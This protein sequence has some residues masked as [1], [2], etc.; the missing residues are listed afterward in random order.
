MPSLKYQRGITLIE[1][2]V[3]IALFVFLIGS[4]VISA[5]YI[6]DS[7]E[8]NKSDLSVTT[9][10]QFLLRKIDWAL[11]GVTSITSPSSGNSDGT[12]S[13]NKAG[14][15]DI[16]INLDSGRVELSRGGNPAESLTAERVLIENLSFNHVPEQGTKPAAVEVSYTA[17]GKAFEMIKYFR[18]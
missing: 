10:A 18:K 16:V 14:V 13:V 15:G 3:Y 2:L 17:N 4:G 11:T 1:T 12:L 8:R 7:S 9:E 5:F 6:I